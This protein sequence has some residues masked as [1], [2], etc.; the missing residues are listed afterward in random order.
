MFFR[1]IYIKYHHVTY[2]PD[3]VLVVELRKKERK[4]ERNR[5]RKRDKAGRS[6]ERE[7]R[8]EGRRMGGTAIKAGN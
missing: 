4:R 2:E 3:T 5:D 7:G 6:G 8:R 1:Q